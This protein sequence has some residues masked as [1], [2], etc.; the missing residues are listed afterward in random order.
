MIILSFDVGIKNLAYYILDSETKDIL[1]WNIID[2]TSSNLILKF[3]T[4][5][6]QM[7]R[8]LTGQQ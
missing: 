7:I 1:D 5:L 4:P 6:M 3:F 2:C 8:S